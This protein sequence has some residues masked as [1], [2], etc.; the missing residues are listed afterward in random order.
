MTEPPPLWI[1]DPL[2]ILADNAAGG[3]VVR[4]GRIDELIPPVASRP[5]EARSFS[6]P[7]RMSCCPA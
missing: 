3:I 4:G 2:G 6:M 7:R 1:R 5:T